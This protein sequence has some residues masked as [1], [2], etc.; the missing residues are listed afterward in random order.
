MSPID[1]SIR[2]TCISLTLVVTDWIIDKRHQ[3]GHSF[4]FLPP[5]AQM[6]RSKHLKSTRLRKMQ[7]KI[8]LKT[9]KPVSPISLVSSDDIVHMEAEGFEASEASECDESEESEEEFTT[10]EPAAPTRES[11]AP[12]RESVDL[13]FEAL[14]NIFWDKGYFILRKFIP[15]HLTDKLLEKVEDVEYVSIF[16]QVY[17]KQ[18]DAYRFQ[19]K[20]PPRKPFSDFT[21]FVK[22]KLIKRC[23]DKR[24]VP[25]NWVFLKSLAGGEEQQAHRD[26]PSFETSR[27]RHEYDTIQAGFMTG[28]MSGTTLIVYESCFA[29]ADVAKRKIITIDKGDCIIFRGDLVHAGSAYDTLNYRIHA[30]LKV[31]GIK[32]ND[33]ATDAAPMKTFKCKFCPLLVDTKLKLRNHSRLCH[34]NPDREFHIAQD[35]NNNLQEVTCHCGKTFKSKNSFRAHRRRTHAS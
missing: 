26:F 2:D 23:A 12:T 1:Q 17:S 9:Q 11:A 18:H 25:R 5:T 34:S 3:E 32:W 21:T 22:E 29:E 30:T 33:N 4:C 16:R 35:K 28:L 15:D 13:D 7:P 31:K 20:F 24:W 6:N 14:F 27:A 10:R 8:R 19:G